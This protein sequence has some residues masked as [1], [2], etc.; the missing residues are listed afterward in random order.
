MEQELIQP[1]KQ[2]GKELDYMIAMADPLMEF[3]YE[4]DLA[5]KGESMYGLGWILCNDGV[6][7]RFGG[8]VNNNLVVETFSPSTKWGQMGPL[9]DRYPEVRFFH[10]KGQ[11]WCLI[12][13]KGMGTP[14][15]IP[16]DSKLLS[17][18]K[19]FATVFLGWHVFKPKHFP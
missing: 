9:L 11:I 18:A 8:D 4:K 6:I 19:A 15:S 12:D 2:T 7:R 5:A 17:A 16:S 1:F 10:D 13:P 14:C 3:K